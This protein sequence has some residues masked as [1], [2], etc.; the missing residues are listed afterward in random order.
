MATA[1]EGPLLQCPCRPIVRWGGS[2]LPGVLL[3]AL[4]GG[5][6]VAMAQQRSGDPLALATLLRV[7]Q[8]ILESDRRLLQ[9]GWRPSPASAPAAL[10]RERSGST[11][12]SLSGCSGTGA[13]FCRFDYRRGRARLAV[14]TVP[15]PTGHSGGPIVLRWVDDISGRRWGLCQSDTSE[16]LIPCKGLG[17]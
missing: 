8:P 14:I 5:A 4:L 11:L 15:S 13:G 16:Q 12:A 1:R 10:D 3:L 17:P 7:G 2:S 6:G 9:L